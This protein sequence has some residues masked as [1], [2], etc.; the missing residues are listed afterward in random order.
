MASESFLQN[1]LLYLL[2]SL[3]GVVASRALAVVDAVSNWWHAVVCALLSLLPKARVRFPVTRPA[4]HYHPAVLV[5]GTSSGI[6]HD[7]AVALARSGYTVFAG[8]R[9]WEDGARV[10]SD[11]LAGVRAETAHQNRYSRRSTRSPGEPTVSVNGGAAS[12][13]DTDTDSTGHSSIETKQQIHNAVAGP[14]HLLQR[15]LR[16]MHRRHAA[17]DHTR[18]AAPDHT[19]S[20]AAATTNGAVPHNTGAGCIIPVILDVV[21]RDSVD[22]A[23]A[24]VSEELEQRNVPLIAVVNNA[25]VTAFGPMDISAPSFIDHCMNVN[26]HGPVR[27]TQK[28][29]PLLRASSGRIVNISS[30]MTWLIGP[31]F[32]VYCASKAA[33]TA[34]SRAWHYELANNNISVSVIEPGVTRTALWS[35]VESQLELHHARL[36]GVRLTKKPRGRRSPPAAMPGDEAV[37]SVSPERS[38]LQGSGDAHAAAAAAA[39]AD[40][41][42]PPGLVTNAASTENQALYNPMIRRIKT[43]NE[44]APIFALPT[45]H[46]VSAIMHALT[47]H[48]PKSTYRV[49]WDARLMGLATWVAS[50]EV[51]EWLCRVVGIVS[52]D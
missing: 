19:R 16:R 26:F 24:R 48:Y 12:D 9:S 5:T 17:P 22:R 10:E 8:V 33:L 29:M 1:H 27:V 4:N 39:A 45:C 3:L 36:N 50:E 38:T 41:P 43:S 51:V 42:P 31:G 18:P 34:A 46:A 23:F 37:A 15:R 6:G 30:I 47:S 14:R 40:A 21:C 35:K 11:F 20:A 2:C 25:G 32:G 28:F 13:T 44:L 49:G 52:E 7:T